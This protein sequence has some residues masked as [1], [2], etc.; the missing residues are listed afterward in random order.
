MNTMNQDA[1][2]RRDK[3]VSKIKETWGR[4]NDNDIALYDGRREQFF[5]RLQEKYGILRAEAED[6]LQELEESCNYR[7]KEG[8]EKAA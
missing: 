4:L 7:G 8:K 2:T 3:L 5:A 1:T 6:R